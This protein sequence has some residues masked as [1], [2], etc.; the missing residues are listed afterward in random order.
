MIRLDDHHDE[1]PKIAP[2]SDQAFRFWHRGLAWAMRNLSDGFIPRGVARQLAGSRTKKL[3]EEL[4]AA[5]LWEEKDGGWKI[6]DIL[7]WNWSKD[8]ALAYRASARNQRVSA[9]QARARGPR[10]KG[11]RF[12]SG[13]SGEASGGTSEAASELTS[14][15]TSGRPA[16]SHS[17]Y[18]V[19]IKG[20]VKTSPSESREGSDEELEKLKRCEQT[21]ADSQHSGAFAGKSAGLLDLIQ[22]FPDR[23]I[24]QACSDLV[25]KVDLIEYDGAALSL[26]ETFT[27]KARRTRPREPEFFCPNCE[28][29]W[30]GDRCQRAEPG[31]R[32]CTRVN[33]AKGSG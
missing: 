31:S 23:D 24:E 22:R 30:Y 15:I 11:G 18:P 14:E 33:L 26:L 13:T 4:V 32:V 1:H 6:H 27:Q 29:N 8:E 28:M 3:T 5:K 7:D 9:G 20:L 12:T 21:L 17:Q 16:H 19:P 2:L 25:D 10:G